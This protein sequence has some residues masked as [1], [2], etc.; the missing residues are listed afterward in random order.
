MGKEQKKENK[1]KRSAW[2]DE[3]TRPVKLCKGAEI[4][5]SVYEI[6]ENRYFTLILKGLVVYLI[7]AGGIGSYLTAI[8]IDFSQVIFNIVIFSTA[9]ICAILYHSWKTE[10][11]GY[12]VFFA[13]YASLMFLFKDYLNSGFYAVINDTIDWASIYF[14]TDGLQ[15]YNER[16]SNR[17]IAITVSMSLIGV[18]MNVLLNNYIL[19]RARYIVAIGLGVTVNI[20]A[21]YMMREPDTIYTVMLLAG[22]VMTYVLKRG[23]HFYLSRRDHIF[24]RNKKGLSY[25]LDFKSLWQT[26]AIVGAFVLGTVAFM[27]TVYDKV[28]YDYEQ[29]PSKEKEITRETFQ[30]FIMLGIFGLFDYYPNNGGLSTGVLGGVSAIRLDYMTDLSVIYTPYTAD[31][32][33]IKNFTG[34]RYRPYD[35]KWMRDSDVDWAESSPDPEERKKIKERVLKRNDSTYSLE[36]AALAKNY[37]E[38]KEKSAQGRMTIT[39]VE[40]PML[41]Y[42]PYYSEGDAEP[43]IMRDTRTY[44]FYPEFAE[45]DIDSVDYTPDPAYLDVPEENKEVIDKFIKEAGISGSDPYEIAASI[46]KYFEENVPYTIRP[47]ATPWRRDFVN[48]FLEKNKKGYCA[49]FASA[50]TLILREMGIPARYCE[51]YAISFDQVLS[52]GEL[53]EDSEYSD[54]YSGYNPLGETAPVRVEATDADAHAWIEMF[55]EGRGWTLVELTPPSGLEEEEDDESFWERFNGIFGDGEDDDTNERETNDLNTFSVSDADRFMRYAAYIILG[56]IAL[57]FIVFVF[58]KLYPEIKYRIDYSKAGPSDKLILKYMRY[59][60][61]RKKKDASFREKMNYTEQIEYLLPDSETE[62]C[63]MTDILERAG[64]SNREISEEDYGY[65][66]MMVEKLLGRKR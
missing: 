9:I 43:L 53:L 27:S 34:T 63:R 39:N 4:D 13:F 60:S 10:N 22:I 5:S 48:Y 29:V 54:Y 31:M 32:V 40:G 16:I 44:T 15:Y 36:V 49:H 1:K 42:Q 64:F 52:Q 50:G 19:R 59:V 30:N 61:R 25:A 35:N 41:P 47:G 46:E 11:L 51:G 8:D 66:D 57:G 6:S 26:L 23:R 55:V 56:L 37:E 65:A 14:G 38:N 28:H 2:L 45:T 21:F 24:A 20:F 7:T 17:Y 12:L 33:Y 18:A 62:A 3:D 58:I